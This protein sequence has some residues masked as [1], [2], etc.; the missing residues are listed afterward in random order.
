MKFDIKGCGARVRSLREGKMSEGRKLTQ[1]A[2][3]A[4]LNISDVHLRKI[5]NG[6]KRMS[7]ELLVKISDYFKVSLDFLVFGK[8]GTGSVARMRLQEV[9]RELED[10]S[11]KIN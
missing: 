10:I 5:E 7:I 3:A 4:D 1:E 9:I 11:S 8:E 2:L 6:Q